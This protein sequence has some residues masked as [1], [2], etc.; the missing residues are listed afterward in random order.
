MQSERA[1][2]PKEYNEQIIN[3]PFSKLLTIPFPNLYGDNLK[4]TDWG[5][6][7][8][9]ETMPG[10]GMVGLLLALV[11]SWLA[12][13]RFR[14]LLRT[15]A[16]LGVLALWLSFG[17]EMLLYGL[18][19]ALVPPMRMVA[20]AARALF[21]FTWA[22]SLAAGLGIEGI[23][24]LFEKNPRGVSRGAV[25]F[26]SVGI[27][28]AAGAGAL[29]LWGR[30]H[31]SDGATAA[32]VLRSAIIAGVA[33]PALLMSPRFVKPVHA[34]AW[35]FAC[36]LFLDLLGAHQRFF[37]CGPLFARGQ[38]SKS[39]IQILTRDPDHGRVLRVIEEMPDEALLYGYEDVNGYG[40]TALAD[41]V[42]ASSWLS[43]R[44]TNATHRV[45]INHPTIALREWFAMNYVLAYANQTLTESEWERVYA[46][47]LYSL[48]KARVTYPRACVAERYH[49][50]THEEAGRLLRT[51]WPYEAEEIIVEG[52]APDFRM[53]GGLGG[54]GR[55]SDASDG[56]DGSDR[57]DR[58]GE[59]NV[60]ARLV[61][62]TAN[63]RQYVASL[64]RPGW[65]LMSEN[66]A[67]GWRLKVNGKPARLYRA[68]YCLCAAPLPAGK[69]SVDLI[70]SP[71][72]FWLGLALSALAVLGAMA[73]AFVYGRFSKR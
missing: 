58:A 40:V 69:H 33:F 49:P 45:M 43:E 4:T 22:L 34:C 28:L 37:A 13:E 21:V 64:A 5:E 60:S 57:S 14:R 66:Y 56:S 70:Y 63:T 24:R 32:S 2:L 9:C 20:G 54:Q 67:Q 18:L 68:Q 8:F 10:V 47:E 35:V 39:M 41:F 51:A 23:Q 73:T 12:P 50:V 29:L 25:A 27:A 11:F 42:L 16:A 46:D 1:Q 38:S 15:I 61:R 55:V 36:V 52:L 53:P 6:S 31:W 72:A 30:G 7:F 17:S 3:L 71:S 44:P 59:A 48:W 26:A 65:L 19:K 62:Q